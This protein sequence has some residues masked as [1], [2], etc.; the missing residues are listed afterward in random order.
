LLQ[1][2][3]TPQPLA[4]QEV[5][6]TI[7]ERYYQTRDPDSLSASRLIASVKPCSSWPQEHARLAPSSRLLVSPQNELLYRRASTAG[8]RYYR[9]ATGGSS[10][11]NTDPRFG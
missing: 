2:R 1:R 7:V 6:G 11:L 5:N 3:E 10:T 8:M 9:F 4:T